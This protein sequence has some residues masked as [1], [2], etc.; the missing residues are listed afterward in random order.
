MVLSLNGM[1][2]GI[3]IGGCGIAVMAAMPAAYGQLLKRE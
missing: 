3:M 1:I 2:P